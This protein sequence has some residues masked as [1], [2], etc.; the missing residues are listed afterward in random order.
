MPLGLLTTVPWP[1]PLAVIVPILETVKVKVV[2]L[3][4][5][6]KVAVQEAAA[7]MVTAPV[8]HPVPLQ[9]A[10]VEPDA[11]VA[12]RVTTVPLSKLEEHVAPQLMPGGELLIVPLPVPVEDTVR[13]NVAEAAAAVL[14]ASGVY[15]EAPAELNALTR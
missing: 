7:L 3:A 8:V 12:V 13:L 4:V 5:A 15:G 6:V 11:G 10:K 1:V 14:Q 9:P 2:G